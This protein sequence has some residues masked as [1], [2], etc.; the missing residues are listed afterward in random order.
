MCIADIGVGC[1]A[2]AVAL[3]VNLPETEIIVIDTSPQALVLARR[4]AQRHTVADRIRFL[5]GDL[6]EPLEATV[7]VIVANLPYVRSGD[8]EAASPEIREHEPRLGLDGGPDGLRLVERLL[9]GAP[10]HLKPGGALFAEIGEQQGDSARTLATESF[11]Q[12]RIEIRQDL[13]GLDR[14]LVV[15]T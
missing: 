7:D 13:S 4:N 6:L 15:L 2:I 9:R 10:P 5:E 11:P 12:A 14:V 3:A 1:G 8:F